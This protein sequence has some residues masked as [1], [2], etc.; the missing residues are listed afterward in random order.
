M[1]VLFAGQLFGIRG[2]D[3]ERLVVNY[4][5]HAV[6]AAVALLLLRYVMLPVLGIAWR[7]FRARR[8]WNGKAPWYWG[9]RLNIRADGQGGGSLPGVRGRRQRCLVVFV[10]GLFPYLAE[11]WIYR[12]LIDH[13][14]DVLQSEFERREYLLFRHHGTYWSP[15]DPE[16]IVRNQLLPQVAAAANHANYDAII[17]TAHSF[18]GLLVRQLVLDAVNEP[19]YRKI[20]RIVLMASPNRGFSPITFLHKVLELFAWAVLD[21][22]QN[23]SWLRFGH[24]TLSGLKGAPWV[25]DLRLRWITAF[26]AGSPP[27]TFQILGGRDNLVSVDDDD[28][29]RK[30]PNFHPKL[31]PLIGHG[32]FTLQLRRRR[33]QETNNQNRDAIAGLRDMIAQAL[34][35]P[36][37][38]RELAAAP[39]EIPEN[40]VLI[41]HG[42][43]D[44]AEWHEE[45]AD[46]IQRLN[47]PLE[48]GTQP[49]RF[50]C[51]SIGYGYFS[52]FQFLSNRA[53]HYCVRTLV[54]RYVQL[55]IKY[56]HAKFHAI[57]HSNG[58]FAVG[59]ALQEYRFVEFE[60][61]YFAG[62]VLSERF[63]WQSLLRGPG[64]KSHR[65]LNLCANG[66]TPVGVLCWTLS[67]L[68]MVYGSLG[69]GGSGGFVQATDD[70]TSIPTDPTPQAWN[71]WIVGDHNSGVRRNNFQNIAHFIETGL[72]QQ[73]RPVVPDEMPVERITVPALRTSRQV[74]QSRLLTAIGLALFVALY[75]GSFFVFSWPFILGG[76]VLI[77]L[78]VGA[79]DFLLVY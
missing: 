56:P 2:R 68:Q 79:I 19:W 77:A 14:D 15:R 32:H 62:S 23:P 37:F 8:R 63:E 75:A 39:E 43:R 3:L 72:P 76:T 4:W 40:I 58:T 7:W 22:P 45:L 16:W 70:L 50:Q 10:H 65:V 30:Y 36:D 60:R 27:L 6:A 13:F 51:H 52:A 20:E 74:H 34:T 21:R 67:S 66:D 78:I 64:K 69:I 41:V 59:R 38:V 17:L 73:V 1:S 24:L 46:A 31:L 71:E 54:D 47:T 53:R 29:L 11:R 33:S 28:D 35:L 42:I 12:R 49:L 48:D 55:R 26:A 18:G 5:P 9:R 25:S 57:A 44:F 61:I